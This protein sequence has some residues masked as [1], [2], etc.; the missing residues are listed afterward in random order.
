MERTLRRDDQ[1]ALRRAVGTTSSHVDR[2]GADR[3]RHRAE[4][5]RA[6]PRTL[7]THC[8]ATNTATRRVRISGS[9]LRH[10]PIP[11]RLRNRLGQPRLDQMAARNRTEPRH[12][13]ATPALTRLVTRS[14]AQLH[15]PLEFPLV[16]I[17]EN[18][19][20]SYRVGVALPA[21]PGGARIIAG[22]RPLRAPQGCCGVDIRW[23]K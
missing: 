11:L 22:A 14:S 9:P 2:K 19:R 23:D 1:R 3:N 17:S 7:A 8:R 20:R 21:I 5:L 16:R 13:P 4:L 12:R 10:K 15:F 6:L 18:R